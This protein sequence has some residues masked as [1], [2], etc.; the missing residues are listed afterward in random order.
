MLKFDMVIKIFLFLIFLTSNLFAECT[1]INQ[2]G[3][4]NTFKNLEYIHIKLVDK[5]K[6][7]KRAS[8]Y[9]ISVNSPGKNRVK[10]AK[11]L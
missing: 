3:D 7:F 4:A 1:K 9:Y 11:S 8:R 6:F 5:D 2:F 10:N